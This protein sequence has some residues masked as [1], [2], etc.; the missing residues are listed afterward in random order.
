MKKTHL[1]LY[2]YILLV[3]HSIAQPNPMDKGTDPGSGGPGSN[4][5]LGAPIDDFLWGMIV[6][7]L[8]Y[9]LYKWY[10]KRMTDKTDKSIK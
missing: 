6:I 8:A 5:H 4:P 1:T 3:L 2:F 7:S 10:Q 9:A